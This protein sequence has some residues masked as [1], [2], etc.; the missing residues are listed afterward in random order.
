MIS[1]ILPTYNEVE[2][3]GIIIPEIAKVLKQENSE[4]EIIVVDD[5]SPD[6]TASV[7]KKLST[8]FPVKIIV[9]KEERGLSRAV[10]Q[11]FT[12]AKGEICLVM[13]ADMSHPI[14]KIPDIIEPIRNKRC[15]VTVGSRNIR[16]GGFEDWPYIRKL[17]SRCAGFMARGITKLSD[18]T[19]GFMAFRKQIINGVELDPLGWKIVLELISKTNPKIIEIPIIFKDRR[20]GKSK[21]N[22]KVQLDYIKHLVKLY[23]F[24][25]TSL[26][27]FF[28][29]FILSGSFILFFFN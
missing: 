11:G 5:N 2:N 14:E 26:L 9:R 21:L 20:L 6:G 13:D 25:Y 29:V 19:S 24:K 3:I 8:E 18:P 27:K 16:G 22:L 17:I 4:Y 1:V 10:I 28:A 12:V 23:Y 7:A 15:D